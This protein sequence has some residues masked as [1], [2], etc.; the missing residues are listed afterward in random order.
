[1]QHL[2]ALNG[3]TRK[4]CSLRKEYA[5]LQRASLM[6]KRHAKYDGLPDSQIIL[7]RRS[8]HIRVSGL[9]RVP[10]SRTANSF[11]RLLCVKIFPLWSVSWKSGSSCGSWCAGSFARCIPDAAW[12]SSLVG[13]C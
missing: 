10:N 12:N 8:S 2:F 11:L 7:P 5:A 6:I 4:A 1:M 9:S 3:A 13:G